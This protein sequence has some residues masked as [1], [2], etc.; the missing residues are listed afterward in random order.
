MQYK[1]VA[2]LRENLLHLIRT[3]AS[4]DDI[5]NALKEY[6]D[7]VFH[8]GFAHHI[9]EGSGK[10]SDGMCCANLS[11]ITPTA[12]SLYRSQPPR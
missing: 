9:N 1:E 6:S 8:N 2:T 4:M 11:L 10:Y 7:A 5:E 3:G 12:P